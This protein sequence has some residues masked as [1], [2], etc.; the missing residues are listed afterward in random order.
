MRGLVTAF[1]NFVRGWSLSRGGHRL[2]AGHKARSREF[3]TVAP[4]PT[5]HDGCGC[6]S[7]GA[8]CAP[9][10]SLSCRCTHPRRFNMMGYVPQKS[11]DL[12][13]DRCGG[14]G[15][16]LAFCHEPSVSRAQPD[17]CLPGDIPNLL[18]KLCLATLVRIADA[19]RVTIGPRRF[20]QSLAGADVARLGDASLA[21]CFAS[22]TL[23]RHQA[24]KG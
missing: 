21:S 14:D 3:P 15:C 8:V 24:Q 19:R 5:L 10:L 11:R 18:R 9:P 6:C 17:L 22:G 13:R 23:R 12:A 2:V 4:S 7:R 20:D 1:P 16:P